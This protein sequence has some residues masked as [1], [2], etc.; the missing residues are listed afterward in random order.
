MK[1]IQR[2]CATVLAA[3]FALHLA[4]AYAADPEWKWD[5]S[6]RDPVVPGSADVAVSPLDTGG[7]PQ[8]A[9]KAGY[10]TELSFNTWLYGWA[11]CVVSVIDTTKRGLLLLF[12]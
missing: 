8:S 4:V 9:A 10:A 3:V 2:I 7:A 11:D 1:R 12:R 6:K 5:D